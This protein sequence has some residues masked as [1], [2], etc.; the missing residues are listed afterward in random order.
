MPIVKKAYTLCVLSITRDVGVL[1]AGRSPDL[2]IIAQW[3]PSRFFNFNQWHSSVALHNYS[4]EFVQ[5]FHLFPFSPDPVSADA[6]ISDTYCLIF[7]LFH[8]ITLI[9]LCQA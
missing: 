2:D 3:K 8:D 9:D 4:D 6:E 1:T 7:H 5:D